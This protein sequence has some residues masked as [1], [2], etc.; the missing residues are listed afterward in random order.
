MVIILNSSKLIEKILLH[1]S[2]RNC[3]SNFLFEKQKLKEKAKHRM[4]RSVT[5]LINIYF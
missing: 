3:Y 4:I 5:K 1:L 2:I